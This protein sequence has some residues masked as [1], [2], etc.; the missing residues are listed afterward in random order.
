MKDSNSLH[1]K[2]QAHIDCYSETDPLREMSRIHSDADAEAA[3]LKWIALSVLHGVNNG[4]EKIAIHRDKAGAVEVLA[5]YRTAALPTPGDDVAARVV[6]TLRAIT[7]IDGPNGRLPLS[8]GMGNDRVE[9]EV[10]IREED[11]EAWVTLKF[12]GN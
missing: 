1:Q 7:H 12:E 5:S 4:A 9:L 3:A 11:G 10:K 2:V 8:L 6:S